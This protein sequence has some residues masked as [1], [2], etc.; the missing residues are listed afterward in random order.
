LD[1]ILHSVSRQHPLIAA[2]ISLA[3]SASI[4]AAPKA[5]VIEEEDNLPLLQP[6]YHK[7]TS[8]GVR[9]H[10]VS[11]DSRNCALQ[12]IDQA[13]GPASQWSTASSLGKAKSALACINAGFFNPDGSPLG[14]VIADGKP[15]GSINNSS[16]GAGFF[17]TNVKQSGIAR[18][19]DLSRIRS[20]L[21]PAYLLQ[22]GPMLSYR[23]AAISGLSSKNPRS[24]SFLAT[25]GSY[26]WLIGYAESATLDQLGKALTGKRLAN[27]NIYH[28]IN[29]DGGR[30]SDLW[31][32]PSV[33]NGDKT[34]RALWN[35]P[36]RN[37]LLLTKK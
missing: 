11:F 5:L 2:A 14:L 28:A 33:R 24:R 36:V 31:V 27:V 12:V 4:H 29:L 30:S 34:F 37:F 10:L 17:Y 8:N 21:A 9:L 26:H 7:V 25:D 15:R 20:Q 23:K 6:S 35:K 32:S 3:L 18:K 19:S 1:R 13:S 22:T 16:L